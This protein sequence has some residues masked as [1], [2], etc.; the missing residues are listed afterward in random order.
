MTRI[1]LI[2]TAEEAD[3]VAGMAYLS[4]GAVWADAVFASDLQRGD[5]PSAGQ[6]RQA[7]AAAIRALGWSG[8][9]GRV[10]QEFG[11]HPETAVIRMCWARR[12]AREAFADPTPEQ[13]PAARADAGG[14]LVVR[15]RLPAEH[16][17]SS[18]SGAVG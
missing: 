1:A 7:V 8:C 2:S 10:A 16:A 6:V 4:I 5:E 3:D 11:D 15:P 9:A 17:S 18:V 12:V 13:G 14:W